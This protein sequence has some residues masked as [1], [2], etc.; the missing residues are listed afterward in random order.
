[1]NAERLAKVE[2]VFARYGPVAV[3]FARFFSVLHQLNGLV[4]GSMGMP[5]RR[6][7]LFNA[8]GAALWVLTWTVVGY[9]V[10]LHGAGIAALTHKFG[11]AGIIV[12][13]IAAMAMMAYL[14]RRRARPQ[15]P[16]R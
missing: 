1:M 4:A 15:R 12:A 10:G 3:A 11:H 13:L 5:W 16:E 7:L 8:L 2:A 9:Y 6:F 14:Y